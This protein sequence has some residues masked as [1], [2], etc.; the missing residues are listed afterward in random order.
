[1]MKKMLFFY[2]LSIYDPF[3]CFSAVRIA[4]QFAISFR[5]HMFHVHIF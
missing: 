4:A 1:M 5:V 3:V 2:I